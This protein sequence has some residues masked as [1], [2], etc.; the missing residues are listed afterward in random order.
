M[1]FAPIWG[2][3]SC[4]PSYFLQKIMHSAAN[5]AEVRQKSY[6]ALQMLQQPESSG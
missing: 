5:V 3:K 6:I 4:I 2:M 1:I